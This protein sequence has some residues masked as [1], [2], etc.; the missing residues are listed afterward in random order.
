[1]L[2]LT[3]HGTILRVEQTNRRLTHAAPFPVRDVADDFRVELPADLT[4][5][6][7]VPGG[8]E[9]VA[10]AR[11]GTLH[12]RRGGGYL[13]V[14]AHAPWPVCDRAEPDKWETLIALSDEEAAT[15]RRLLGGRWA[16]G[17]TILA[18][19]TMGLEEGFAFRIGDQILDL[20]E[21][22]PQAQADG[23]VVLL[24]DAGRVELQPVEI[25]PEGEWLLRPAPPEHAPA[26]VPD[27]AALHATPD[28]RLV[29]PATVERVHLPITASRA[30]ADWLYRAP[31]MQRDPVSGR[32]RFG[33]SVVHERDRYVLLERSVEGM[34]FGPHGVSNT[35]GYLG[36]LVGKMPPNMARE[37]GHEFISTAALRTAPRLTGPHA[38]FYGGNLTNYFH[39]I[40]DAMLPLSLLQPRLPPGTTLLL[41]GTLEQFRA[42]PNGRFDHIETLE[43]F[44]FGDM[45]RVEVAA[46]VCHVADVYW[47]DKCFIEDVAAVDLDAC[48]RRALERLPAP[49]T[50]E[51]RIYIKRTGSRRVGNE[52]SVEDFVVKAGFEIHVMEDL[53]VAE[54]IE[55]FRHAA[56]VI[57]VHGAATAN[58]VFCPPGTKVIELAP[59]CGYRPFFALIS[60]K[61]GLVHGILPCPTSDGGFFGRMNVPVARLRALRRMLERRL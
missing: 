49:G 18:A 57:G 16:F 14:E 3:W 7:Q 48:R 59:D 56:W 6:V 44:G 15:L 20:T 30:D 34:I 9:A 40:I 50:A 8:M 26:E 27:A 24:L 43:A 35:Q 47:A 58:L 22:R 60:S 41:P 1:M 13:A 5:P 52:E 32:H 61:L 2:L 23:S 45:P 28:S 53:S 12:L 54:Q 39:W 38:V 42:H 36:N 19:H 17:G 25:E 55:L 46:Q 29:L 10:G 37:A 51:R 31:W 33:S 11:P 4:E 21:R